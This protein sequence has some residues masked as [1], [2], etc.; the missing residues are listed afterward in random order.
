V[1][2]RP[3]TIFLKENDSSIDDDARFG[4]IEG[5]AGRR[6]HTMN[7]MIYKKKAPLLFFLLP[8]FCF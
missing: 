1:I 7:S 3:L 5:R 4:I 2:G 8:A 6:R